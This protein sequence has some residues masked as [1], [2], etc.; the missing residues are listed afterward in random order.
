MPTCMA[1]LLTRSC[2]ARR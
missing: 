1:M 2:A